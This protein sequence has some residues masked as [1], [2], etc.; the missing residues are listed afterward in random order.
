MNAST[1]P[2]Q[3]IA[4]RNLIWLVKELA[5]ALVP[6]AAGLLGISLLHTPTTPGLDVGGRASTFALV[7]LVSGFLVGSIHPRRWKLAWISA[8]GPLLV[9]LLWIGGAFLGEGGA[10]PPAWRRFMSGSPGVALGAFAL[11]AGLALAGARVGATA[12]R[13]PANPRSAV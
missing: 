1:A 3:P 6:I 4:P 7:F 11:G 10:E 13:R 5:F 8:W 9:A 2:D 12:A